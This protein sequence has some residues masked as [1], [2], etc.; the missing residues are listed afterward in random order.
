MYFVLL[1]LPFFE[2][3][4]LKGQRAV[5]EFVIHYTPIGI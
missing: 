2:D 5:V 1:L 4:W 3:L